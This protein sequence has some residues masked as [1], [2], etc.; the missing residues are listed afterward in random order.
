MTK[1]VKEVLPLVMNKSCENCGRNESWEYK[2]ESGFYKAICFCGCTRLFD[3]EAV[4]K[5]AEYQ[6]GALKNWA[7]SRL[8]LVKKIARTT[9]P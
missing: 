1:S 3:P 7:D 5:Y 4:Q 6:R 9:P 8:A 2:F